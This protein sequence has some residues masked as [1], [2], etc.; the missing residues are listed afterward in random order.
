MSGELG[1]ARLAWRGF[2]HHWRTNL[3]V[4]AGCLVSA[5]VLVGALLVGD[6]LRFTLETRAQER[7][8]AA[9]AVLVGGERLFTS[10]L[11]DALA[12]EL[13]PG[14]RVAPLL[15]LPASARAGGERRAGDVALYG[16]DA[17]F[18][19]L[20]GAQGGAPQA[21]MA[22]VSRALASRLDVGIGDEI[23]LRVEQPSALPRDMILAT[24]EDASIGLRV[25]VASVLDGGAARFGLAATP[26]PP[27]NVFVDLGW[28]AQQVAR[29]GRANL[30]LVAGGGDGAAVAARADAALRERWSLADAE[31][32]LAALDGATVELT[33]PRV[34]LDEVVGAAIARSGAPAVGVLTYFVNA[35]EHDGRSTPYSIVSALGPL[36]DAPLPPELAALVPDA[37]GVVVNDWLARD[38]G[39]A[40][41]DALTLRYFVPGPDRRLAEASAPF[42]VARVVPLEGAADDPT[43]MPDFPGISASE[44]CRDWEPGTPIDLDAIDDEDEAYWE[45]HEGAPKAFLSLADG[46]RLWAGR[47]GDLTAVRAPVGHLGAALRGALT[48][49]AVGL[50]F[51]DFRSPALAGATAATDF[52]G[53]FL[54]LSCFLIAAALLL[55]TLLFVF[56][57][58]Q[59]GAEQGLL[60]ALGY[61]PRHVRRL[62]LAEAG[63]IALV[64]AAL[65]AGL[66]ALYTQRVLAALGGVWSG[67][68]A[69]TTLHFHATPASYVGGALATVLL[70]LTAGWVALRGQLRRSAVALLAT[71][72]GVAPEAALAAPRRARVS[73]VLALLLAA[74]ALGLFL[75]TDPDSGVA[76]AG[77]FFGAGAAL[78]LAGVLGARWLLVHLRR[79]TRPHPTSVV[80]LGR[81]NAARRPGRS[82]AVV[83]LVAG[84]TFLVVS[85]GVHEKRAQG[86][87]G[88]EAGTGGFTY[89]G[90]LSLP[91]HDDLAS[92]HGREAHGLEALAGVTIT[93]L[94]QREGDDASCLNLGTPQEPRLV[95]VRAA[96]LAGRFAFA[97]APAGD[98]S[99]W[100]LLDAPLPDGAVPAIADQASAQW[101]MKKALGDDFTYTDERG[102]AFRVRLVATLADSILQGDLL[103]AESAFQQRY[104]SASGYRRLLIDAPE[105]RRAEIADELRF[106]LAPLGLELV[107]SAQRLAAF[108]AVQNTYLAI[109]QSL[110]GLGVL[111]GSVGLGVVLLRN[112]LERRRE[113]AML[114]ALGYRRRDVRAMLFAE[115]ALLLALGFGAGAAAALLALLPVGGVPVWSALRLLV[116]I[117][118]NGLV[119]VFVAAFVA[120]R[121]PALAGLRAE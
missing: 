13:G 52:G 21:G 42:E 68:V 120:A 60:L 76:A 64:G 49:D 99:P 65:G 47:F 12:D 82:L 5:A 24:T 66:G 69:G 9:D 90:E 94:R 23:V 91:L 109:F 89:I 75:A 4:L 34:F 43:L 104:P 33:S 31:L 88:R 92:A 15:R 45:A 67:A 87:L 85:I 107:P 112:A 20:E 119:W 111:L 6:S 59:R 10:T 19:A 27:A 110:G 55:T 102:R 28:L 116:A 41:G 53:L 36:G 70:A 11:A 26:L 96:E 72:E 30:I 38:L 7:I 18:G 121:A 22:D 37:G 74:G 77:G 16:I 78:L 46:Q 32:E 56:G 108:L 54:G 2:L 101:S 113:L 98:A 48:P 86:A 100:A 61:R 1:L 95:G 97:R 118:M 17:R 83:A 105:E 81:R 106:A 80:D 58:E 79:A 114:A 8:G 40:V 39:L 50:A 115:H 117:G 29:P 57:V 71:S 93:S 62:V 35:L 25:V 63:L 44:S 51:Q 84:G 103:I 14:V 73:A 3:G